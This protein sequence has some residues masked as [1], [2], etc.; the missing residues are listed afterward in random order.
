MEPE[1]MLIFMKNGEVVN[2]EIVGCFK[3]NPGDSQEYIA[4]IPVTDTSDTFFYRMRED[5][6]ESLHLSEIP[7]D[8]EMQ[9][10]ISAF[11]KCSV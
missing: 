2:T 11:E 10:V 9:L 6:D 4:L 1:Y 5:E 8:A 7:A 3:I